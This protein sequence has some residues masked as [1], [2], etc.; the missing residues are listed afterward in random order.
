M[1]K[2]INGNEIEKQKGRD[3]LKGIS[4]LN[5]GSAPQH[6]FVKNKLNQMEQSTN[7]PD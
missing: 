6:A 4:F 7:Q 3:I 5:T 1:Y 2:L